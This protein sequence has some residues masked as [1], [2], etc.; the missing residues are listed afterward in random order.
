MTAIEK[1]IA[2]RL[3]ACTF[4]PGSF[5]KRFVKQL[6]NWEGRDMTTAGK[7]LLF[8]LANKYRKQCGYS[9]AEIEQLKIKN[10]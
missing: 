7:A 8:S 9:P 6:E 3:R 1:A 2:G 10:G 4:L 5:D